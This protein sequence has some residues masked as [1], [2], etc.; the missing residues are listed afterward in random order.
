M[1]KFCSVSLIGKAECNSFVSLG[2]LF[3]RHILLARRHAVDSRPHPK[4]HVEI[5][6]GV[7][8]DCWGQIVCFYGNS[9]HKLILLIR[10]QHRPA[11]IA[12]LDGLHWGGDGQ[13]VDCVRNHAGEGSQDKD[14]NADGDYS[15]S[16]GLVLGLGAVAQHFRGAEHVAGLYH[17]LHPL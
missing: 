14:D 13:A 10:S 16:Q 17:P 5:P 15:P 2:A 11:G 6:P 8:V 3:Q 1:M 9:E 4:H 12:P 7:D